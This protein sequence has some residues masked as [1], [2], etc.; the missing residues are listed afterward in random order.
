MNSCVMKMHKVSLDL[1]FFCEVG[2][3]LLVKVTYDCLA[4]GGE[5][6]GGR[7]RERE[8][9]DGVKGRVERGERGRKGREDEKRGG[10]GSE[11]QGVRI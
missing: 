3:K 7:G 5:E 1:Q 8:V 2:L 4:A 6:G 10:R 11:W 9:S